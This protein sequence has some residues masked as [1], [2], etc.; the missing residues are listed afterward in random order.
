MLVEQRLIGFFEKMEKYFY[1]TVERIWG[2]LQGMTI[3]I[4]F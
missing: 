2:H 1:K 4:L 3:F